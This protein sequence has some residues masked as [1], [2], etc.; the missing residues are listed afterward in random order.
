MFCEKQGFDFDYHN[1]GDDWGTINIG[2]YYFY[3]GDIRKDIDNDAPKGLI[4]EWYWQ[5]LEHY[6]KVGTNQGGVNYDH[7]ITGARFDL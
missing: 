5:S 7:Y 4:I 2:D 1:I 3:L 6:E